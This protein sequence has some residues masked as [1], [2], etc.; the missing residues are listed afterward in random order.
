MAIRKERRSTSWPVA[1]A[2]AHFD[3]VI[4]AVENEHPQTLVRN[5]DNRVTIVPVDEWSATGQPIQDLAS[6]FAS[7]QLGQGEL[8]LLPRTGTARDLDW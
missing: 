2:K 6:F 4:D 3:E 1:E 7:A 5:G 8:V